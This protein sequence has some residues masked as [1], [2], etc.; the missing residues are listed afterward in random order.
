MPLLSR[1]QGHQR[2][3]EWKRAPM[4]H[5]PRLPSYSHSPLPG[6]PGD[7]QPTSVP[8]APGHARHRKEPGSEEKCK[9]FPPTSSASLPLL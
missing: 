5:V 8:L 9:A 4:G 6:R 7:P 3:L 1:P 2:G